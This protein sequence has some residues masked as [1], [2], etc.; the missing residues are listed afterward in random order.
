MHAHYKA[1]CACVIHAMYS[2]SMFIFPHFFFFI[3]VIFKFFDLTAVK[4]IESLFTFTTTQHM[5]IQY[6]A[7]LVENSLNLFAY[8][9]T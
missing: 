3:F 4:Y 7:V 8:D 6:F 5:R 1:M 2:F 9:I